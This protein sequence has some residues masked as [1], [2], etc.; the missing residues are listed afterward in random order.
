MK[1]NTKYIPITPVTEKT[2][3]ITPAA[4]AAASPAREPK[5]RWLTIFVFCIILLWFIVC[6][7][8]ISLLIDI[9]I[10]VTKFT[11][12]EIFGTY[13]DIIMEEGYLRGEKTPLPSSRP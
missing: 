11:V 1:I 9:M 2:P 3:I 12:N 4:A 5:N 7:I 13:I 8:I 6:V 10:I